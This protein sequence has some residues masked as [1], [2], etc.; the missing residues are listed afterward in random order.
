MTEEEKKALE[1]PNQK[2]NDTE[3]FYNM[4]NKPK[5]KEELELEKNG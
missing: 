3:K 2:Q 5:T 4:F 1:D